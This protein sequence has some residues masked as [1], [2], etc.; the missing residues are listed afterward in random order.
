[1]GCNP[2]WRSSTRRTPAPHAVKHML[3]T[4]VAAVLDD[5]DKRLHGE[6][7]QLD[8]YVSEQHAAAAH[9]RL[10]REQARWDDAVAA[11][12]TAEAQEAA[13]EGGVQELW[14]LL[15]LLPDFKRK[16]LQAQH[17]VLFA[18]QM[19]E[20][21]ERRRADAERR[22][23]EA[24]AARAAVTSG[25]GAG[26][27]AEVVDLQDGE[28]QPAGAAGP[29]SAAAPL[30]QQQQQQQSALPLQQQQEEPDGGPAAM[31][32]DSAEVAAAAEAEREAVLQ[33]A[34]DGAAFIPSNGWRGAV[35]GYCFRE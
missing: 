28:Q 3:G 16:T 13:L 11:A 22:K 33:A 27:E 1:M 6:L 19:M 25:S 4:R 35:P 34:E 29:S 21:A 30:T 17:V 23:A 18:K 12:P 20:E 9:R 15:H 26:H 24:A 32:V 10:A 7:T 14:S 8:R 5:L 31:E 2:P